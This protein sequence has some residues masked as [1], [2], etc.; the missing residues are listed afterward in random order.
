MAT[1]SQGSEFDRAKRW[2]KKFL[3]DWKEGSGNRTGRGQSQAGG[4]SWQPGDV[5]EMLARW[6]CWP[7]LVEAMARNGQLHRL[8]IGTEGANG[9]LAMTE[10]RRNL[11]IL[12]PPR[13]DKTAGVLTLSI[14]AHPGPVV[15]TSTKADVLRATALVRSRLGRVWHYSPDGSETPPGASEL[16]WSPIPPSGRWATAIALGKA[17][18]DVADSGTGGG[19]EYASYFRTKAGVVIAALLH[20]AALGDK[21][22]LWLLRAVNG[23]R[24]A[25]NQAAETLDD[26]LGSDAQIASSD[27]HGVIDLDERTKGPIFATT[28]N[29]FAAYRLPGALRS[30]GKPGGGDF[31]DIDK[32]V[33]GDPDGFNPWRVALLGEGATAMERLG[34]GIGQKGRFDTVYITASSEQQNLVAPIIAGFLSQVREATFAR[35][36]ADEAE[37]RFNRPAV[38]WALDEIAGIAPM[39]DLPETLSQSGGQNLLV[40]CCLQDLGMARAKWDKAADAFLTLFGNVVIHAGIR[41]RETLQAISTV[42][43]KEWIKVAT[44]GKNTSSGRGS[45]GSNKQEGW[46]QT[47]TEQLVDVLDPGAVAQGRVKEWPTFVLGLTPSGVEWFFSM[48]YFNTAPWPQ[49]LVATMQHMLSVAGPFDSALDLPTPILDRNG[50]G[51]FLMAAGGPGL[52]ERYQQLTRDFKAARQHRHELLG[53]LGPGSL[54]AGYD[55][56]AR[57]ARLAVP[58]RSYIVFRHDPAGAPADLLGNEFRGPVTG[59][60][61]AGGRARIAAALE[62]MPEIRP[63]GPDE[64]FVIAT[65]NVGALTPD[66]EHPQSPFCHPDWVMDYAGAGPTMLSL[67][68]GGAAARSHSPIMSRLGYRLPGTAVLLEAWSYTRPGVHMVTRLAE[69]LGTL[70]PTCVFTSE[71][72]NYFGSWTND[73]NYS[74]DNESGR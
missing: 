57:P 17:M 47:E 71:G 54:L 16:R 50:D 51:Q 64:E 33:A 26:A 69:R 53:N 41:D 46:Q 21:D 23:D 4:A 22:M 58:Q 73:D 15:S 30:T 38:L 40:A 48:P 67:V 55:D 52:V 11:L 27:L 6:D 43:G 12:G 72:A 2:G 66:S 35:Y 10:A 32:F 1:T 56:G 68:E 20:A 7:H 36:R 63:A 37:D 60:L 9:A 29:A 49:L 62:A 28:A 5:G 45:G 65:G 13:S 19:G 44:E 8:V 42:A 59:Y 70:A 61:S 25:L 31:F 3:A 24:V 18:A 39:R 74:D 14:L 34:A